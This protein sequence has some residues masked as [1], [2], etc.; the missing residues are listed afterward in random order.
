[1]NGV[2]FTIVLWNLKDMEWSFNSM[3][4]EG[5]NIKNKLPLTFT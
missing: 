5:E 2:Y 1:M 4:W 3:D